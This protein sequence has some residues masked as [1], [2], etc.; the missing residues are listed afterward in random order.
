MLLTFP[1]LFAMWA[2]LQT[3]IELRGAPWFGWIHDL[4]QHD[5]WYVLPIVMGAT[6]V[7]QQRITPATGADPAQQKMMMFMP[8]IFTVMFLWLPAGAAIYYGVTNLWIVGQQYLT[9][10]LIGPPNVRAARPPAE[11]RVK[12][13]GVG[14]TDAAA[15]ESE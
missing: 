6:Q 7:W 14:K 15:R 1:V 4:T 13:V 5:P 10:Y 11:R 12:R 3:S 8:V 2:M 9:N